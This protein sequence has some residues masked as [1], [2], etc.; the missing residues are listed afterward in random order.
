MKTV[1]SVLVGLGAVVSVA[2][3]GCAPSYTCNPFTTCA[4][5][6]STVQACCTS[7]QCEYRT[8][9]RT[10]ACEGTNCASAASA[11]TTYCGS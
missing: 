1:R 4:R 9:G 10:F 2:V 5:D 11:L 6:G 3:A 7:S 8:G